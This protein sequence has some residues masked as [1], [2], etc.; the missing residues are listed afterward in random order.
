[1]NFSKEVILRDELFRRNWSRKYEHLSG[2]FF[3]KVPRTN[4][5]ETR[6]IR[7]LMFPGVTDRRCWPKNAKRRDFRRTLS[8]TNRRTMRLSVH[9]FFWNHR[10][11]FPERHPVWLAYDH[12]I[13]NTI[14]SLQV[15]GI[16]RRNK[17]SNHPWNLMNFVS[18]SKDSSFL[19]NWWNIFFIHRT[20]YY[21]KIY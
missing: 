18:D 5:R 1:M 7:I 20:L 4:R 6:I 14:S 2:D 9:R 10:R 11:P 17:R 13:R 21:E 3:K 16:F 19:V 15:A 8:N 12:L